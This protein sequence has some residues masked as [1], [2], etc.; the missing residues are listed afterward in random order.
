MLKGCGGFHSILLIPWSLDLLGD[1]GEMSLWVLQALHQG[2][3][4]F[5]AGYTGDPLGVQPA[6]LQ[7][8]RAPRPPLPA[9]WASGFQRPPCWFPR[10]VAV[11]LDAGHRTGGCEQAQVC[12]AVRAGP[13]HP[14]PG[15][16]LPLSGM[17]LFHTL[18]FNSAFISGLCV[19]TGSAPTAQIHTLSITSIGLGVH[20]GGSWP[21]FLKHRV[22]TE[23][24]IVLNLD[25][26][27]PEGPTCSSS[28]FFRVLFQTL[29]MCLHLPFLILRFSSSSVSRLASRPPS[30]ILNRTH[31]TPQTGRAALRSPRDPGGAW[32]WLQGRGQGR[33]CPCGQGPRTRGWLWG[34]S[35]QSRSRGS[36]CPDAHS[37]GPSCSGSCAREVGREPGRR[38]SGQAGCS[39]GAEMSVYCSCYGCS[40]NLHQRPTVA[41]NL[42]CT[43]FYFPPN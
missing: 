43:H 30:P 2:T 5:A 32:L 20:H 10:S 29:S 26:G 22:M 7:H 13:R 35:A 4:G 12:H 36:R 37:P 38:L 3:A 34:H 24:T 17:S 41:H 11:S 23:P 21:D 14:S 33:C 27:S 8:T 15:G 9:S 40:V 19:G 18:P 6:F 25:L 1:W 39:V 16:P 42:S 28:S 31:S